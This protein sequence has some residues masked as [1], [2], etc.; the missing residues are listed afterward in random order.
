MRAA[1]H[2]PVAVWDAT[3]RV[4]HWWNALCVLVLIVFGSLLYARDA[5]H[6]TQPVEHV[7]IAIHATFGFAL[8]AGVLTRLAYMLT[9]SG[10]AGWRDVLPHTPA[11]LALARRTLRYYLSGCRGECP[12]YFGH[13]P[14]A[15]FA[16]S[17]FFLFAVF[18][19]LTGAAMY[20]FGDGSTAG[21][22]HT[23]YTAQGKQA[24]PPAPL[25]LAHALGGLMIA[26]F[27]L[28]HLLAL[29]LHDRVEARGLASSMISGNKFFTPDE[30]EALEGRRESE[31]Q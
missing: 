17:G 15:G 14:L 22:A 19:I 13:N 31:D 24:W 27:V 9:G 30:L 4:C 28:V 10:L 7:L 25:M 18:Q 12:L 2:L 23:L 21:Y 11:Q 20:L 6:L 29:A 3:V 16:Y 1:S 5:L 26:V 8:A